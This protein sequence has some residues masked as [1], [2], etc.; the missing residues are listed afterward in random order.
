MEPFKK[1]IFDKPFKPIYQGLLVLGIYL[2][3]L[4][5]ILSLKSFNWIA[6]E[7]MD[8]WKYATSMILFYV[9]LCCVFCFSTKE[10][11]IYYRDS[12]FTYIIL[13]VLF[14]GIS[15]WLSKL[16]IFEAESYS[17]ILTVFSIIFIVMLTI[18]NLVRKIVEIAIKQ[19]NKL[20][21]EK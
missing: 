13:L 4:G 6:F 1:S 12:I 5:M 10:K 19:D 17:W 16:S 20:T 14:S 7:P 18:I 11:M 2:V 15:Q 21:H 3:F 8:Y 9:M